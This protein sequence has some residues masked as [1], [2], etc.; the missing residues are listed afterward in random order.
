MGRRS[1]DEKINLAVVYHVEMQGNKLVFRGKRT[2][3]S[4]E[5]T[6]VAI[7]MQPWFVWFVVREM[8]AFIKSKIKELD[9]VRDCFTFE[10]K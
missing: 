8:K 7:S 10:E 3:D 4:K 1:V 9:Y 6:N 2:L 5:R